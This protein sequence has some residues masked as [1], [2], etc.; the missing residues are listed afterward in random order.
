MPKKLKVL[1]T[2]LEQGILP[3]YFH[4]DAEVSAH[5]LKSLYAAGIRAVEYT[6]RGETAIDNFIHLRKISHQELPGLLLG[7]GTIKN[8]I[9]ATEFVNAEADFIISPGMIPEVASLVHKNGLLWVPGCMTI[10]EI[11]QAEEL[12]AKL[13][14]LFPGSLLGP[15]FVT[16]IKEIFPDLL[17]MPTGGVE[18]EKENLRSWFK[19]GVSAVGM[20]S[21]LISKTILDNAEYS[22]I[23]D[24]TAD[25]LNIVRS[26]RGVRYQSG[27]ES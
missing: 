17:F 21:K 12:E 15:S 23:T 14:K 10:T 7:A 2:I 8:R 18:L 9:D 22:R 24:L 13:I 27:I 26:I 5:V 11:I 4:Q 6:N 25:A 16:A 1:N 3:L 20:G 19:S